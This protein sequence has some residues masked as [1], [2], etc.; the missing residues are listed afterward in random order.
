M[1]P[2]MSF[3][4]AVDYYDQTR[5]FPPGVAEQVARAAAGLLGPN[6][7]I[8][9][10]GIGTGRIARPLA[11]LGYKIY[12]LDISIQMMQRLRATLPAGVPEP[13]LVLGNAAQIPWMPGSFDATL[14]V[15]VFHLIPHWQDTLEEIIRVLKPGGILLHGTDW[16]P[17]EAPSARLRNHWNEI[18]HSHE[19]PSPDRARPEKIRAALTASGAKMTEVIAA[20][21][22]ESFDISKHL[23]QLAQ[24]MYSSTWRVPPEQLPEYM[25]ELRS[26][27]RQ[28]FGGLGQVYTCP[29]SFIWQKFSWN[30]SRLT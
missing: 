12:G 8:M 6:A 10:V 24:G 16:H 7:T 27:A 1:Q 20:R 9:E 19:V 13:R 2:L 29:H 4:R 15:H 14:A 3:D 21:W 11:A 22:E 28:E 30:S 26:W 18:L 23:D 17:P 25:E 5:G